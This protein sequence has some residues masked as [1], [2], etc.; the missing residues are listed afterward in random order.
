MMWRDHAARLA[1]G[2]TA[3]G[4]RWRQ[5][6]AAVPRH[7]FV[8]RW[9][10]T[11]AGAAFGT[12]EAHD[13]PA[14]EAGWMEAA[15]SDQTLVT[16]VA[17]VHADQARTGDVASGRPTSSSTLPSLVV[18]M[19]R[20]GDIYEGADVLD[21][22]TG[23]GYSAALLA[24]L[25]GDHRVTSIDVDPYLVD[26][27][28]RRLDAIGFHPQVL[29]CDATGPLPGRYDRIVSMVSVKPIPASWLSALKPGGRLVTVL[30][31]TS[32]ILTATKTEDGG[33]TGRIEPDWAMF[34]P[35]RSAGDYPP[36]LN[37][38]FDEVREQ[39]GES[40][41]RGRYPIVDVASAW[42]LQSMLEVVAPGIENRFDD[43]PD[44]SRVAW[45]LHADGSWARAVAQGSELPI[46]HQG[47]PRRLWDVLDDIR[48]YWLTTGALPLRGAQ[49]FVLPDGV[50][51]LWRAGWKKVI[52]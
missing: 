26:A 13:G 14:D 6:V 32:L 52:R 43:L 4:S 37:K 47:G 23:S 12:W 1:A 49:V 25:L 24:H 46:V 34:M 2:V 33:A 48:E 40:T 9:W 31:N 29:A 51:R 38:L 27:A 20:H 30:A 10:D 17:G 5:A 35:V 19:L 18:R 39:T 11:P 3:H 15:Y 42:E 21:V 7:L 45:M 44:G 8:P 22:A 41:A 16:Q 36:R 28:T 50:I